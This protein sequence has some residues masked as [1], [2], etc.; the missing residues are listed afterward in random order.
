M[1]IT[2]IVCAPGV[3]GFF[4]DDQL[5][6]RRGT[7]RDG[8]WYEG[9]PITEGF[10]SVRMP[11]ASL[12]LGLV[13]EDDTV[14]WG[15][16]MS[17]QYAGVA[18]RDAPFSP[19]SYARP[20]VDDWFP[21]I[22]GR[23]AS[24]FRE[25]AQAACAA[26]RELGL[27]HTA[28]EYGLTQALLGAAAHSQKST[29][30]EVVCQ[31]YGLALHPEAVP[32]FTQ[33]G[34]R[35]RENVDKMVMKQVEAL[36]HGLI[37]SPEHFGVDGETFLEYVRWVRTRVKELGSM[38][39]D[40]VLHFDV[41]G[42]PGQVFDGSLKRISAFLE[43]VAEAASPHRLRI[44][45]PLICATRAEQIEAFST[46]RELL[47]EA[48][49]AVGIVADE[50]CNTLEDINAFVSAEACDMVQV[51]APDLG[52]LEHTIRGVIRCKEAGVGAY[53]GGS[54][55][56]TEVSARVCARV[57]IATQ[58]DVILAKPGMGVDEGITVVRNEQARALA[59]IS[60][61]PSGR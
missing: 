24:G 42:L 57:A 50:W 8:E 35:R 16:A 11:A 37:S 44:E 6:V 26:L 29:V 21:K 22:R 23:D 40:P 41:Y 25:T 45:S 31:E 3:G 12:G 32:L 7:E 49:V 48:G 15:D 38:G 60:L 36:P 4:Y 39:Y 33:S 43:E 59:E 18:G 2:S 46:L 52:S 10:A 17:V 5:A 58:P 20:L 27:A 34:E 13:P 19:A 61:R 56:E 47:A 14:H 55:T 9:P 1:R 51:K 54:C 53:L 30:T 28:L